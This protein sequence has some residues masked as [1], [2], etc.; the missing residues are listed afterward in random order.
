M[1]L[2]EAV[3]R[4]RQ[5]GEFVAGDLVVPAADIADE[6]VAVAAAGRQALEYC[7]T[8]QTWSHQA[9]AS[10]E[11][12]EWAERLAPVPRGSVR[13]ALALAVSE[14]ECEMG[15]APVENAVQEQAAAVPRSSAQRRA[16]RRPSVM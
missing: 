7:P 13:A 11:R 15:S 4:R 3:V 6:Q 12:Q 9:G 5:G 16:V 2:A 10:R 1:V 8:F 14:Y